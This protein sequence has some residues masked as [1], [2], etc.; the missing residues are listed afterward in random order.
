[1]CQTDVCTKKPHG[2][3]MHGC[4]LCE[5]RYIDIMGQAYVSDLRVLTE[6]QRQEKE[7]KNTAALTEINRPARLPDADMG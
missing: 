7:D 4:E 6:E 3:E 2:D 5:Q 1:M